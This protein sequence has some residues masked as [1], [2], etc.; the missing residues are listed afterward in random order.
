MKISNKLS[1]EKLQKLIGETFK[2]KIVLTGKEWPGYY[3]LTGVTVKRENV[4]LDFAYGL[5]Y[6]GNITF[7]PEEVELEP[8]KLEEE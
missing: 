3:M 8:F 5:S 2:I 6:S 4:I 1:I 7:L